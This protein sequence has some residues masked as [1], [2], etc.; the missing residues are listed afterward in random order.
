MTDHA[1]R[2]GKAEV[3]KAVLLAG[4][5]KP[6]GWQPAPGK[7]LDEHLGAG[8]VHFDNSLQIL[9]AGPAPSGS[10]TLGVEGAI[11][12]QAVADPVRLPNR[13]GWDFR[14]IEPKQTHAY[15]FG[16]QAPMGEASII[17]NWHRRI[18]SVKTDETGGG[19]S[20][21]IWYGL[22][23]L[24]DLDLHLYH[25][26]ENGDVHELAVSES[27]VDNVEHIYLKQLDP[28]RYRL[29]VTRPE[30]VHDE[31]WDYALAWR[32]ELLEEPGEQIGRD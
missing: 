24:A 32:V 7:P 28:G 2:A 25:T 9:Q 1:H 26:D 30:A 15:T 8:L 13:M 19:G 16:L 23:R 5:V 17:L 22:P 4:A 27:R 31:P 3:I 18:G 12:Q 11:D 20:G 6:N 29:E 14:E 10:E 21:S